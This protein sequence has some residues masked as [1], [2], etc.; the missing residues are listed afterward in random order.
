MMSINDEGKDFVYSIIMCVQSTS[1]HVSSY[2]R[3]VVAEEKTLM[4]TFCMQ[5]ELLASI[6]AFGSHKKN[7]KDKQK[8]THHVF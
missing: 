6:G 7:I 2:K 3:F 8:H 5:N 4:R 1:K